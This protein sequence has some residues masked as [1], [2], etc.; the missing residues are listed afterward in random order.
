MT[1]LITYKRLREQFL[2]KLKEKPASFNFRLNARRLA[3][4]DYF[5]A[6]FRELERARKQGEES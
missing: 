6:I 3:R 1:S 5:T 4:A 2:S